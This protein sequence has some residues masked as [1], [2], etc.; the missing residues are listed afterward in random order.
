MPAVNT[1]EHISQV[2]LVMEANRTAVPGLVLFFTAPVF[3]FE[4]DCLV[5]RQVF[6]ISP[7]LFSI[8]DGFVLGSGVKGWTVTTVFFMIK[9]C[10][11]K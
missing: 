11:G 1:G 10:G 7:D 9:E 2:W 4:K 6:K 3:M 5:V 8:I